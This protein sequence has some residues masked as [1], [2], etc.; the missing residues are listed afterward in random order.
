[1]PQER[2]FRTPG[3]GSFLGRLFSK[4]RA[5]LS[6]FFARKSP[7]NFDEETGS[8][9]DPDVILTP[10]PNAE[11][12]PKRLVNNDCNQ[13]HVVY[14][15]VVNKVPACNAATKLQALSEAIGKAVDYFDNHFECRNKDCIR[16]VGD[17]IWT[18]MACGQN[19]TRAWGAVLVRFRCE[20]EF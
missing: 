8:W 4:P 11:A 19:P 17:I 6:R 15:V 13:S 14:S 12:P 2:D 20:I 16:K 18:G 7:G 1:M 10:D 9:V 5:F 3:R